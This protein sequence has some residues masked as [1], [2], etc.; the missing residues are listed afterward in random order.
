MSS[1]VIALIAFI[2]LS[3]W[4]RFEDRT[5]QKG[6]QRYPEPE[7]GKAKLQFPTA[8][9]GDFSVVPPGAE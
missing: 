5:R 9:V 7:R 2:V 4:S 6:V 1:A 3:S 8:Q